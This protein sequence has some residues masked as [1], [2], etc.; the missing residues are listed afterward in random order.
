M[1]KD[2]MYALN[3]TLAEFMDRQGMTVDDAAQ[4]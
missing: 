3:D 1:N 4:C 2:Q